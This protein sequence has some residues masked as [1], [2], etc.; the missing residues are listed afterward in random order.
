MIPHQEIP[1]IYF[2]FPKHLLY[3]LLPIHQG[4]NLVS[5]KNL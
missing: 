4:C 5:I 1:A 2:I 3:K